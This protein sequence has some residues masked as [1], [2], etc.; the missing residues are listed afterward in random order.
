MR[1][2]G[3][4]HIV[5]FGGGFAGLDLLLSPVETGFLSRSD[6]RLKRGRIP[7]QAEHDLYPPWS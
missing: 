4:P 3:K 2:N 1:A 5:V 7:L 6:A